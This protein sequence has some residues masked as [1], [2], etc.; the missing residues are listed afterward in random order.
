MPKK[1]HDSWKK[2]LDEHIHAGHIQPS[3]S[4]YA[5][6]SFCVPKYQNG[7]PE[8]TVPHRW[9]NDYRELNANTIRD[10]YPLPRVDDILSDCA[11]GKI[12]GKMDM[13]NS[14]FQTRV[15]PDDIHLTAIQMPW[16]LYEWTVMPMGG[17][18]SPSTHQRR[19]TDALRDLIGNICHV[20]LDNI[21]IWS[22]TIEEHKANV[23]K[24]LE[25]LLRDNL[26]CNGSKS[27]LFSTELSFLG[28]K[29]F[30]NGIQADSRKIDH[31]TEWPQPTTATNMQ[32][33]LGLTHYLATFLPALAEHT[34]VLTLL[35]T[36]ECD[37]EFPI[38]EP[39]HQRAF[40]AIKALVTGTECLTVIDYEDTTK[41]IFVTTDTSELRT[42]AV[43]SFGDTW[44]TACPVAYDSYQLNSAEKNYP[45][46]EKELLAI[47]K[48]LKKWPTSLLGIHF[49]IFTDHRTLEYFQFQKDMSHR[50]MHWSMYLAD[51]DYKLTYIQGEDN[52]AADALSR[53]PDAPPNSMLAACAFAHTRS[54]SRPRELAAATLDITADESLL[55]DI[56]AG[57]QE[58]EF[59]QQLRKDIQAG[60]IEGA[61]DENGLLY[62]GQRLLIPNLPRIRELF[63]N[64]AHDTLGHFGFDKSYEA[65]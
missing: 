21:I 15:H 62:V 46:H 29:I 53:M 40:N 7:V 22:Q 41:R 49:E 42:G 32:G 61:R 45:V 25:A 18:N 35:T 55:R 3:S 58:D 59:A 2:L 39:E 24:V 14:S 47:I 26:F 17:C 9:V 20:Y 65:L 36:K 30:A 13:T 51:F 5:S 16:G 63:Y 28:H 4:E 27:I 34:S 60:S 6:P 52:T 50:Q 12:F 23:A 31:V 37:R 33:F 57:Y 8:L 54:P 48:A 10:N 64:L 38:W 19:M 44:E 43:L 1:Y 11:K 56:T